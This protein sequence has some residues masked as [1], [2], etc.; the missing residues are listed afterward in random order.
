M[1]RLEELKEEYLYKNTSYKVEQEFLYSYSKREL[2]EFVNDFRIEY[3]RLRTPY[4]IKI[5]KLKKSKNYI[6]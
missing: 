3:I 2:R 4:S 6:N 1:E 5:N